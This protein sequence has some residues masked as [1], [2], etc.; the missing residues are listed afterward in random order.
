MRFLAG[1]RRFASRPAAS[2][3]V[4]RQEVNNFIR[5]ISEI[6]FYATPRDLTCSPSPLTAAL[7]C[8][9]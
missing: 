8:K 9:Y 2:I 7:Q 4:W 5:L 1:F 3:V 6:G